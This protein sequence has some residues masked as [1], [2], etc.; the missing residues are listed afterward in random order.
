MCAAPNP[1]DAVVREQPVPA[2]MAFGI[3]RTTQ[4]EMNGHIYLVR[5]AERKDKRE[6]ACFVSAVATVKSSRH[7]YSK[8]TAAELDSRS[9]EALKA[10]VLALIAHDAAKA[11]AGEMQT[12]ASWPPPRQIAPTG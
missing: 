9:G 12:R 7:F 11:K 2:M 10:G 6:Y 3:Y 8:E 4:L 5:F 1:F